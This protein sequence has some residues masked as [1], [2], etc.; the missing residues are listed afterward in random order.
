MGTCSVRQATPVPGAG[1]QGTAAAPTFYGCGVARFASY[2]LCRR[3]GGARPLV[4]SYSLVVQPSC[5][6]ASGLGLVWS[7]T[8][9]VGGVGV[10]LPG[11]SGLPQLQCVGQGVYWLQLLEDIAA[12]T[13]DVNSQNVN[14]GVPLVPIP[15]ILSVEGTLSVRFE[16]F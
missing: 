16:P 5:G 6:T 14:P 13:G 12:E 9:G 15:S 7:T 8:G 1:W 11:L 3:I 4:L 2:E 10:A